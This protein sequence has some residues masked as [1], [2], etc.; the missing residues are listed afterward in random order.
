MICSSTVSSSRRSPVDLISRYDSSFNPKPPQIKSPN[1][2]SISPLN[3][4]LITP[5]SLIDQFIT[6]SLHDMRIANWECCG[7]CSWILRNGVLFLVFVIALA[8]V[9]NGLRP[10]RE[11]S[12]T[13]G[14]EWLFNRR[15]DDLSINT[16]WNI[17]G[18]YRGT[19]GIRD[20]NN[21][22]SC[23]LEFEKSNG[24][25]ILELASSPT[26]ITEVHYV[27][28]V[29]SF[30][31]AFDNND[32]GASQLRVEV[33]NLIGHGRLGFNYSV[34][35]CSGKDGELTREDDY[36]LS[37][38]YHLLGI[39]SSQVFQD[40]PR[41]KIRRRKKSSSF[42]IEKRCN[43][44]IAAQISRISSGQY[45]IGA[46]NRK[47]PVYTCRHGRTMNLLRAKSVILPSLLK[48][49]GD[50]ERYQLVGSMEGPSVDDD[51]VCFSPMLLNATSV[52][53][54]GAAKVSILVIGQQ[55][56]MDAYLCLL[57]L[58][59]GILVESLFNAFATA[60]FFKFVVFSIF[61]MRYLLA[62]WKANRPMNNGEG[63][64]TLRRE[65]SVLYS[66]FYHIDGKRW[67]ENPLSCINLDG[68]EV[69]NQLPG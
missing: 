66:R 29:I 62:I 5:I 39:F 28:G 21:D 3:S 58:T 15:D 33:T 36:V 51:R 8:P 41:E 38:P 63:W 1:G 35:F 67:A 18:I 24:I 12:Q 45:D 26:K 14:D 44:E 22:S 69:A 48:L 61:E 46:G 10:L 17:T 20:S 2:V 42:D 9:V 31:D 13:W 16:A 30:H 34:L 25:A 7:G 6:S 49:D 53:I 55:A 57:H 68:W 64:E 56:I 43:L 40:S 32:S 50:R 23:L 27:Q 19:W 11:S 59:A 52:N 60:A 37:N 4:W 47:S 65:L 54:E